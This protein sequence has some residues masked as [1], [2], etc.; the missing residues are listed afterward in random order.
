MIGNNTKEEQDFEEIHAPASPERPQN[1]FERTSKQS[2]TQPPLYIPHLLQNQKK[3][4]SIFFHFKFA[5]N[6]Q[7]MEKQAFFHSS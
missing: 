5:E 7:R 3:K 2:F 4:I 6:S 1:S